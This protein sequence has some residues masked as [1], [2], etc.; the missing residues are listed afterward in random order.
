MRNPERSPAAATATYVIGEAITLPSR[1]WLYDDLRDLSVAD[2]SFS[3][4]PA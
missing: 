2:D 1:K 4:L 3:H